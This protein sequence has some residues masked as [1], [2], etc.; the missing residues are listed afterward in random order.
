MVEMTSMLGLCERSK[1]RL[2]TV[3]DRRRTFLV[4]VWRPRQLHRVLVELPTVSSSSAFP[5]FF[6]LSTS[7][8][9]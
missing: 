7:R 2:E 3:P 4:S 6:V 9:M 1:A 8:R 5:N